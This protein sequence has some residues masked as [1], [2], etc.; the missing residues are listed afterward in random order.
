LLATYFAAA[1]RIRTSAVIAAAFAA[2]LSLAQR[3]LSTPVRFLRR[4]VTA[5]AGTLEVQS[6]DE[7]P[8]TRDKL[9]RPPE[10]ALRALSAAA[11][12]LAVALVLLRVE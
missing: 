12:A 1:E 8:L 4:S 7:V 11:V 6:G 2:L 3:R 10:E 5:V 9:L